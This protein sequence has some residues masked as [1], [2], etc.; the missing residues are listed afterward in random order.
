[1]PD[2][3]T[4]VACGT[5]EPRKNHLLL[6]HLWRALAERLGAATP[7]LVLVGRRGWEAENIVDMLER[8]P[9]IR[10]HVVEV[11]GLST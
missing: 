9:A 2:R 4:F 11:S 8:C 10:E 3:P 1:V 6:L 5:I 7:R